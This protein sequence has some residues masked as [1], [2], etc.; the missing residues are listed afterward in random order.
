MPGKSTVRRKYSRSEKRGNDKDGLQPG[1]LG[2]R[3]AV[4]LA[5]FLLCVGYKLIFPASASEL[6]AKLCRTID[7]DGE[8]V[9]VLEKLGEDIVKGE[10]IRAVFATVTDM[11]L[12]K[13]E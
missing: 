1:V 9:A 3:C 5:A 13:S 2:I 4:C 8:Y 12:T 6:G 10:D 11:V 7:S